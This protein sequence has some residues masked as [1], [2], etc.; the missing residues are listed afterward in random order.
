MNWKL[1]GQ[2]SLFGLAMGFATVYFIPSKI[3]PAFWLPIFLVSAWMIARAGT[4]RPLLHGVALGVANSA[5][6]TSA[7]ILLVQDYLATHPAEAEMM[8]SMPLPDSP[9]LMMAMTGSVIGVVSGLVIGLLAVMA[10][11]L[12][13]ARSR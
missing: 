8:K 12:L 10:T 13:K 7:H 6:I 3:E 9:R 1:V 5:W 2:L 11:R 4:G